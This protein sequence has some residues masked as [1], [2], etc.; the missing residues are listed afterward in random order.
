MNNAMN[1]IRELEAHVDTLVVIPNDRLLSAVG[2]GTS[3]MDAF[4]VVDDVLMQGIP[5]HFRP[6]L[7]A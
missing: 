5:G 4:C 3:L 2:K 6:D 7:H 1:G